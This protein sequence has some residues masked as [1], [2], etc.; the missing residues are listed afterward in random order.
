MMMYNFILDKTK[1]GM[2]KPEALKVFKKDFITLR[3]IAPIAE[4]K[5]TRP[6]KFK[7]VSYV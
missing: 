5:I 2:S 6:D 4:L 3:R 7:H 1:Q